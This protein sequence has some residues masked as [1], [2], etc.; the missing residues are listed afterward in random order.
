MAKKQNQ[1]ERVKTMTTLPFP[2]FEHNPYD[3]KKTRRC[4][5]IN[6]KEEPSCLDPRRS[7]NMSVDSQVH[8]MLFEG[9]LRLE[10]DGSLSCAQARSYEVDAG[11]REYTFHL[12][13]TF[14]SN[15]TPVTAY[16]F[17]KTWKNILDPLFPSLDPQLLFCV[18]NAKEAKK[19]L[20]SLDQVGIHAPDAQTLV[21]E[22]RYSSTHFLA[23]TACSVLF[24]INQT[25][26][27]KHPEWYLEAGEHF[28]ANGPFK[29]TSWNHGQEILL[30]KNKYYHG[31]NRIRLDTIHVTMVDNGTAALHLYASG[32]F[33][34]MGVPLSLIPFE[35]YRELTQKNLFHVVKTPAVAACMF[36]AQTFPFQNVHMRKAFGHALNR[37]FLIET[38]TLLKEEPALSIIHP[39]LKKKTRSLFKDRDTP[40][41]RAYFQKGLDELGITARELKGKLSFSFWKYDH[42]CP[43]L[44]FA[45]Q[46][47]WR[48]AFDVEV[49]IDPLDF[50]E[51][52]EKGRKGLFSMGYFVFHSIEV[53]DRFQNSRNE[54]NYARWENQAYIDLLDQSA[55]C[56][57]EKDSW[58]VLEKA[59]KILI[60]E[61]P[62]APMFYWNYALLVQPYVKGLIVS[63]MGYLYFD[64]I[65]KRM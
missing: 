31:A 54:R 21:V 12:K 52:H 27:K 3:S 62:F 20:V 51:L 39:M 32:L 8:A 35:L 2:V 16:D 14:W 17:E 28:V 5:W 36:N 58:S 13:E 41:A 37:K 15:G 10:P 11:Q 50:K 22:L 38:I 61:M 57:A 26:E 60:D 59:E 56:L 53:F 7:R 30:E 34:I 1:K 18:K 6:L 48:E 49:R 43:M 65:S 46:E 25:E 44:A 33:D 45:L 63:P 29:L 64:R 40:R 55:Q 23:L 9:L 42:G 24:P 47:Q 4:L 19:G